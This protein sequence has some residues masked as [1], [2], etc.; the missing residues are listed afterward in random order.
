ML[1]LSV[2][3]IGL[4]LGLV[5][6]GL[7]LPDRVDGLA[8]ALLAWLAPVGLALALL[9]TLT[10]CVPGFFAEAAASSPPHSSPG[11]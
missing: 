3:A 6:A 8:G 7:V 11:D 9:G 4:G 10:V 5:S 1:A 2:M